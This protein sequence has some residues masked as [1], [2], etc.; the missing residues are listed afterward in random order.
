MI[1]FYLTDLIQMYLGA[2][3]IGICPIC[4]KVY[5]VDTF[6]ILGTN[7]V[8][9]GSTGPSQSFEISPCIY[10]S[11]IEFRDFSLYLGTFKSYWRSKGPLYT[12]IRCFSCPH[13]CCVMV[14]ASPTVFYLGPSW[15]LY[16]RDNTQSNTRLEMFLVQGIRRVVGLIWS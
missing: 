2:H 6:D 14:G 13:L 4:F 8:R 1:A 5:I 9:L 3:R 10:R 12:F 16:F 7:T 15:R 11:L